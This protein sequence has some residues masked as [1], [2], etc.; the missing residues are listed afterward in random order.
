LAVLHYLAQRPG[1]TI[2]KR[3]LLKALWSGTVVTK[4]VVKECIRAVR[5]ALGDDALAPTYLETVGREGYRFIGTGGSSQHSVVSSP[6]PHPIP[7]SR[8]PTPTIVGRDAE[9]AQ[10]H[11]WLGKALNGQSHLIFVTG[12]PGIGKTTLIELFRERL[13][14]TADVT[15]GYGQCVEHYGEG[16]AYLPLLEALGRLCRE[17]NGQQLIPL[18]RKHA[19]TWLIQLSGVLPE[20]E[21]QALQLQVQGATQQ[22]MLRELAEAIEVGTVRRPLV[23][24][25]ED[26]HWSDHSTVE[27]LAYLA[28]RR[29]R[30]R[31][32]IVATYRPADVVLGSHSLKT[33]KQELQA[34]GQCEELRLELLKKEDIKEYVTRRFP[35]TTASNGLAQAVYEHTEGNALFMVNVVEELIRQGVVIE[36]EGQ[37]KLKGDTARVSIP[38]T[39]RQLIERQVAQLSE[40]ERRVLEGASVA[41]T[42][43]AVAAVAAGLKQEMDVVEEVC[44]G[45]AWQGHFLQESGIAEW[46]DGT[47]SGRYA[48]R[49]ALYQNVLYERIAEARRVRLHRLIGEHLEAGYKERAQEIAAELAVHFERGRDYQRAVQYLRQAGENAVRRSAYVEAVSLLT[50]GL[51]LF[52]TLPNAPERIQQELQLQLALGPP[53]IATT[54]GAASE[55]KQVYARALELCRQLGETPQLLPVLSGLRAVYLSQG[56]YQTARGLAEQCLRLVQSGQDPTM[57]LLAHF[58]IGTTL[59]FLG[60]FPLSREHLEQALALYDPRRHNPQVSRAPV[61]LR[62]ASL[63]YLA[64]IL[65]NLGYPEQAVRKSP[66]ALALAQVLS[67]PQSSVWALNLGAKVHLYRREGP[68]VQLQ[69]EAMLRL[70]NKQEFPY[71][72]AEGTMLRGWALAEQ[73]REEEGITQMRQGLAD[74]RALE[75]GV[76]ASY[77]LSLPV[78]AYE[79]GGQIEEGLTILAEALEI[80]RKTGESLFEAEIYRLKGELTLQKSSVRSQSKSE[81]RGP[82]SKKTDPRSLTPDPQ[83]EAEACFLKAIEVSQHQQAK[84]LELRATTSLARLWQQQGK[85][86]QAHKMLFEIYGW[87]TEGFDTKDLQEAKALLDALT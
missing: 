19:P 44:E 5:D 46:P 40:D 28:R 58:G 42:E 35:G 33:V 68:A 14:A 6:L 74:W 24:V 87:F 59:Y 29:Q 78:A 70:A 31:L 63:T 22:R 34:H 47:V 7:E 18:L 43:L 39:L 67:H 32:L 52:K 12:E 72:L 69:A 57:L 38:D 3:E 20:D 86:Q 77:F 79:K 53:L 10:L 62:I 21:Q 4:A 8:S 83:T 85:A 9:V 49:H 75:S 82:K 11:Q 48:F 26:L 51:E 64:W 13:Q 30:A 80:V 45:I 71:W 50:R 17:A 73:G 1:Q 25:L 2:T 65:W 23:L 81:V 41:G 16:E 76:A 37:W 15:I 56:D 60:E 36:D 54:S 61:D 66:E 27:F 84:S 55:V